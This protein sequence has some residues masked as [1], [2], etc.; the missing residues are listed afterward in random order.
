M[1][2]P[3]NNDFS[4]VCHNIIRLLDTPTPSFAG[5]RICTRIKIISNYDTSQCII[6]PAKLLLVC[7]GGGKIKSCA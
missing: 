4:L 7:C 5:L 6:I 3:L 2:L 1:I